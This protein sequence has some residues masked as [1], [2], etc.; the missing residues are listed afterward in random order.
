LPLSWNEIRDRSI[1]FVREWAD[2]ASEGAEVQ[3]FW[4]GFFR[5][6]GLER[7]RVA[8]FEAPTRMVR[9]GGKTATGYVDLFWKGRLLEEHKWRGKDLTRAQEGAIRPEIEVTEPDLR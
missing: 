9:N 1:A 7:R 6:V 5:V 3:S 8:Q 4:D 2:E